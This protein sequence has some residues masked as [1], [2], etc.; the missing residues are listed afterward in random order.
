MSQNHLRFGIAFCFMM[1]SFN[2]FA[3]IRQE[4]EAKLIERAEDLAMELIHRRANLPSKWAA[5]Q[6][7]EVH[8]LTQLEQLESGVTNTRE[9]WAYSKDKSVTIQH[10]QEDSHYDRVQERTNAL[11][12]ESRIYKKPS[13]CLYKPKSSSPWQIVPKVPS[14]GHRATDPFGWCIGSYTATRKG[15]TE[16][17]ID[18]FVTKRACVKATEFKAGLQT[19]WGNPLPSKWPTATTAILFDKHTNLPVSVEWRYFPAG[20]DPKNFAKLEQRIVEKSTVTWK[21][22]NVEEG[23]KHEGAAKVY[24]PVKIE[25]I[26]TGIEKEEHIEML[27]RIRWLINDQVADAIFEDPTKNEI[28]EPTFPDYPME[29]KRSR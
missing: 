19:V 14:S 17:S 7:R 28:V 9:F 25:N 6:E 16:D 3:Q 12:I 10:V 5:L 15:R 20:W 21:Q 29:E 26:F 2:G 24:L 27:I 22:F 1:V 4:M 13:L 18:A 23:G 11:G 8:H